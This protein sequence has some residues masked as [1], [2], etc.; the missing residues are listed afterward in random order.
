[1]QLQKSRNWLTWL[2]VCFRGTTESQQLRFPNL[3]NGRILI[4]VLFCFSL[5]SLYW[6]VQHELCCD[7][8]VLCL[9]EDFMLFL[10]DLREAQIVFPKSLTYLIIWRRGYKRGKWWGITATYVPFHNGNASQTGKSRLL[11]I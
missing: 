5:R 6:L 8:D 9:E 4:V 7:K 11:L 1:M 2:A 3:D 10:L